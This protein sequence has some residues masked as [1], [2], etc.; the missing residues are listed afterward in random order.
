MHDSQ[1]TIKE[2]PHSISSLVAQKSGVLEKSLRSFGNQDVLLKW[3]IEIFH[4]ALFWYYFPGWSS[5][6]DFHLKLH[7]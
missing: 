2:H 5:A 7:D 3:P 4:P 6:A 1:Y